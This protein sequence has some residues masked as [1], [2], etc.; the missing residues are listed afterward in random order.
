[1]CIRD[2]LK[3]TASID[4][5]VT[6]AVSD[7][8]TVTVKDVVK[9]N[10]LA[11]GRTYT[12]TGTLHVKDADGNDAGALND[13]GATATKTFTVDGSRD[14]LVK[15]GEVELTFTVKAKSLKTQTVVAFEE[16]KDGDVVVA[17]H[18][19]ISDEDQ[20]VYSPSIGTTASVKDGAP[21]TQN[22][23]LI[24]ISEPTRLHK[25]SRMPSSA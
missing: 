6:P 25:V 5:P 22:L 13:P 19:D 18:S 1:M 7:D 3:T 2:R 11:G 9:W 23:S 17:T 12:V 20:T 16:V 21:T 14:A 24:H 8:A 15:E 10:N 4:K